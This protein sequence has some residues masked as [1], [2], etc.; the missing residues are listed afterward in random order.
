MNS[1]L[2]WCPPRKRGEETPMLMLVHISGFQSYVI[3]DQGPEIT[4]NGDHTSSMRIF[5]AVPY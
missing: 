5:A 2:L 4:A 3:K 1:A